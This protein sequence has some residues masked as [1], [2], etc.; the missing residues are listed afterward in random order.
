[1]HH[2]A[3]KQ[4]HDIPDHEVV[5]SVLADKN[6]F[7]IIVRRYQVPLMRYIWRMGVKLV[8]DREDLLQNV[9]IKTYKNIQGY[10]IKLSFSSWIYRIA[11]NEVV[12]FFRARSVRP[13]GHTVEDGEEA[14][15]QMATSENILRDLDAVYAVQDVLNALDML[16]V[17]YKEVIVLKFFEQKTYTEISDILKIP[18]GTVATL[19][20]RAKKKLQQR[21]HYIHIQ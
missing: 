17:I 12:D 20:H 3:M 10:N 5:A 13:E 14:L 11:H 1:M 19:I 15:E 18:E 4:E 16:D 21:L 6:N 7:G 9:F 8:Q 2:H